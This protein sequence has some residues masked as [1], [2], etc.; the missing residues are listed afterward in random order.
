MSRISIKTYIRLDGQFRPVREVESH[1]GTCEY[2]PG[3]ISMSVDGTEV[4]GLD[5][6]DDVNW[7]WPFIV[8]AL[9]ECR[10]TGAGK[11][12]FP[13]QPIVFRAEKMKWA[14]NVMITVV[15]SSKSVNRTVVAPANE[16]YQVLA[17][18]GIEFFQELR[19]LCGP[20]PASEKDERTLKEWLEP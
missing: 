4:L 2:V 17:Q 12:F 19:R 5:L 13:D 18:S 8:Q 10:R 6:W 14:G 1:D 16:L 3:A 9:D 15:N 7:L 20:D 11:R